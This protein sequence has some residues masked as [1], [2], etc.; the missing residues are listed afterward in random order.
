MHFAEDAGT[1]T[2]LELDILSSRFLSVFVAQGY[3]FLQST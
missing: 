3:V 2:K 1:E